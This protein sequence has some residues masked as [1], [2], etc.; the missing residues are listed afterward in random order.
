MSA[1]LYRE[2]C[3]VSECNIHIKDLRRINR[4]LSRV[5][6]VDNSA[7]SYGLQIDNGVPI[8]P[9]Y[10]GKEDRELHHLASFL[11]MI[12]LYQFRDM[13]L[14]QILRGVFNLTDIIQMDDFWAIYNTYIAKKH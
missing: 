4:P 1:R 11:T 6:L 9:Y 10:Q 12:S 13:D 7:Y 14:R 2:H 5:L 3:W 8:L